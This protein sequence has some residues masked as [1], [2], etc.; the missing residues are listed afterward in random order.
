MEIFFSPRF[1]RS[2]KKLPKDL[3]KHTWDIIQL[4]KENPRNQTLRI[5]KLAVGELWA[6]SID[7]KNRIIFQ[8]MTNGSIIFI[9]VGD[10]S[11]YRK[12]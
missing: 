3:Q 2:F 1:K 5:H 12:I 10:H 6:C 9:N 4:F 8:F 11:I 7:Y